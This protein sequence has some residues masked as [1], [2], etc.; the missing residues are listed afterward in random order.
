MALDLREVKGL[1]DGKEVVNI[2]MSRKGRIELKVSFDL[3][4][5]QARRGP[6]P[7][8]VGFSKPVVITADGE[9]MGAK[10]FMDDINHFHGKDDG[11]RA[12]KGVTIR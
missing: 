3:Q 11:S 2:T 10:Q 4:Q 6:M 7:L 1:L 8:M 12:S 9:E 5:G